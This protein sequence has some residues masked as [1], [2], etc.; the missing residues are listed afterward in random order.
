MLRAYTR[1]ELKELYP[2]FL[3]NRRSIGK[4]GYDYESVSEFLAWLERYERDDG[5]EGYDC[6]CGRE[7]CNR[8]KM[9]SCSC[10]NPCTRCA[11]GR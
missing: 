8:K 2:I 7:S 3:C 9:P 1:D 6:F 5:T 4:I 11:D 10:N